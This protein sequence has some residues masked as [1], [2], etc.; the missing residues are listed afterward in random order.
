V[1]VQSVE[2]DFFNFSKFIMIFVEL[3]FVIACQKFST[4]SII[5]TITSIQRRIEI[6]YMPS[7]KVST[8]SSFEA[9][10]P[11]KIHTHKVQQSKKVLEVEETFS[12]ICP[13]LSA[14]MQ[15]FTHHISSLEPCFF[16]IHTNVITPNFRGENF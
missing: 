1:S 2:S 4:I 6:F 3:G 9:N 8:A 13:H 16:S 10:P 12:I 7:P 15:M 14:K 11:R 5:Q